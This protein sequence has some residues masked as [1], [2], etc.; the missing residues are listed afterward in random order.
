V[1][2]RPGPAGSVG[3]ADRDRQRQSDDHRKRSSHQLFVHRAF[4][5]SLSDPVSSFGPRLTKRTLEVGEAD[6]LRART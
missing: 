5:S 2:V 6:F 4:L 1:I 3:C